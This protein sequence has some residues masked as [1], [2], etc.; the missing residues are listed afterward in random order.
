MKII[1][2]KI[3]LIKTNL[4]KNKLLLYQYKAMNLKK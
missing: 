2:N 3:N 4:L 1:L